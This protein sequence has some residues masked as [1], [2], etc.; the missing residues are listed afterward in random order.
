MSRLGTMKTFTESLKVSSRTPPYILKNEILPNLCSGRYSKSWTPA[1]Q[2]KISSSNLECLSISE[3][4]SELIIPSRV[5]RK[6]LLPT[7][8]ERSSSTSRSIP[9]FTDKLPIVID[10]DSGEEIKLEPGEELQPGAFPVAK[11]SPQKTFESRIDPVPDDD[12]VLDLSVPK[13][14]Q[15]RSSS[16]QPVDLPSPHVDSVKSSSRHSS[17]ISTVSDPNMALAVDALSLLKHAKASESN[18]SAVPVLQGLSMTN[19]SRTFETGD[20]FL[21]EANQW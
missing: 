3:N 5:L 17:E 20:N 11:N 4:P 19:V 7:K 8:L 14:Y 16:T 15:S 2:H 10:D 1:I 21:E 6:T 13:R 18:W 12:V 9:H